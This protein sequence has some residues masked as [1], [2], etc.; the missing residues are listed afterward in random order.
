MMYSPI[1]PKV[2]VAVKYMTIMD[3][4][5]VDFRGA[6]FASNRVCSVADKN[7]GEA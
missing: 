3:G 6:S 5:I 1:H 2:R 7:A 4:E